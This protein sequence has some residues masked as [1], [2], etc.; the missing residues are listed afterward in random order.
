MRHAMQSSFGQCTCHWCGRRKGSDCPVT[1]DIRIRV[2]EFAAEHGRTWKAKL[3]ELWFQGKDE[4][5]LR[6]ARN[7]IGP[8]RLDR[9]TPFMLSQARKAAKEMADAAL[10]RQNAGI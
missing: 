5:N 7:M 2:A 6:N 9:I 8:N 10:A 4:G 3:R 1:E